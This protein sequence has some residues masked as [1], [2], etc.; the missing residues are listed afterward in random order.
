MWPA[1]LHPNRTDATPFL[2]P[3]PPSASQQL[4]PSVPREPPGAGIPYCWFRSR[5]VAVGGP[6]LAPPAGPSWFAYVSFTLLRSSVPTLTASSLS[7]KH[8]LPTTRDFVSTAPHGNVDMQGDP[9]LQ[10]TPRRLL[11]TW[12]D[13]MKRSKSPIRLSYSSCWLARGPRPQP[14]RRPRP[15]PCAV[16]ALNPCADR[17]L[18]RAQSPPSPV[19]SPRPQPV[20]EPA[21]HLRGGCVP[22]TQASVSASRGNR[23][24][25]SHI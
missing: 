25:V 17:A 22:S 9:Y 23:G 5:P 2:L 11:R 18:T 21:R 3:Y 20:P 6:S 8:S 12:E 19:R 14:V 4:D 10:N 16:P 7:V 24:S 15:H 13:R 1:C